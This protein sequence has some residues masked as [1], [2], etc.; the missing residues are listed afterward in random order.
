M[1]T[2]G[3]ALGNIGMKQHKGSA[4]RALFFFDL[5]SCDAQNAVLNNRIKIQN[6]KNAA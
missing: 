5:E 3:C 1:R 6:A 4:T 2:A